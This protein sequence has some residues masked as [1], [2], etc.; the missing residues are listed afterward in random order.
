MERKLKSGFIRVEVKVIGPNG[1][2][3]LLWAIVDTTGRGKWWAEDLAPADC[4]EPE[5]PECKWKKGDWCV[6][7]D[8][9][10]LPRR[11]ATV[12]SDGASMWFDDRHWGFCDRCLPIP[13]PP[14]E[15][16]SPKG[17][18][19]TGKIID[20][21][22]PGK[23]FVAADPNPAVFIVCQTSAGLSDTPDAEYGHRRWE[24]EDIPAPK[25]KLVIEHNQKLPPGENGLNLCV[26][27]DGIATLYFREGREG[28]R[29]ADARPIA[30]V[31][32]DGSIVTLK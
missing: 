32:P 31:L 5:P 14:D 9:M 8:N 1:Y 23:Q 12:E 4:F 29:F 27:T 17:K 2:G 20:V 7:E 3:G 10:Q 22:E 26:G 11:V 28:G 25:P 16:K 24:V 19:L 6:H 18:R 30:K 13:A 15:S 21:R